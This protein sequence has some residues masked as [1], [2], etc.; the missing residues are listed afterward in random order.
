GNIAPGAG[1][2]TMYPSID[3]DANNNLGMT[4]MELSSTEF[5]SMYVTGRKPGDAAGTMSAGALAAAGNPT[6]TTSASRGGDFSAT[7][8]DPAPGTSFWSANEFVNSGVSTLWSTKVTN[9]SV[10][11]AAVVNNGTV[12]FQD[13]GTVLATV[14]VSGGSAATATAALV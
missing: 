1:I 5:I 11:Q 10:G 4:Y 9:F 7:T 14:P 13:G 3:I 8:V 12:T 6:Y 2:S